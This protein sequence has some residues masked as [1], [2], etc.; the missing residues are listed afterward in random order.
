MQRCGFIGLGDQGASMARRMID[1]G[2]DVVLW[3]RRPASL[4][5]FADSSA[6]VAPSLEALAGQVDYCG[7]CVVDD[8]GVRQICEALI[9][10]MAP[11]SC[12]VIHSTVHPD[13]CR[14]LAKQAKSAGLS[15]LDAPVSGGGGRAAA[16]ELTV[17]VGGDSAVLD[18]VRPV[19]A[20]F[21]GLITHL[22]EVG[23]G[24][25]AKLVNNSLM[26]AN[27]AVAHLAMDIAGKAGLDLQAFKE[28]VAAS[29]G[30]SFGFEVR[31]R[32][33]QPADFAHGA[34]LLAKDARLL[35]EAMGEDDTC[36]TLRQIAHRFLD[37][38][39]KQ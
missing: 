38:A 8:A 33:Q 27:L 36:Q 18:A 15:L 1:A 11:G 5:P 31:S 39:L 28:L 7:I 16:G 6:T 21:A 35:V 19:L 29:S 32:M 14:A 26:A 9:P 37:L 20:S 24:Q 22:G 2:F 3:A 17:M 34:R 13:L 30:R 12:I 10:N 4:E 25:M 23:A